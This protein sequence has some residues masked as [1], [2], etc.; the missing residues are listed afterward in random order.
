MWTKGQSGNPKG[1]K[2]GKTPTQ[3]LI[4]E[5]EAKAKREGLGKNWLRHVVELAWTDSKLL[6]ALLKKLIADKSEMDVTLKADLAQ[7]IIEAQKRIKGVTDKQP[8]L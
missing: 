8:G 6:A 5:L 3:S 4:D 7:A 2:P 1:R